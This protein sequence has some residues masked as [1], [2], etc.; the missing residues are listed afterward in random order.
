LHPF[1]VCCASLAQHFRQGSCFSI[2]CKGG[3]ACGLKACDKF[4][5]GFHSRTSG[6]GLSTP[7]TPR[8]TSQESERH[9]VGPDVDFE[10]SLSPPQPTTT[11]LSALRICSHL[12]A[13]A[14]LA[15]ISDCESLRGHRD[16]YAYAAQPFLPSTGRRLLPSQPA[17]G[18][19]S[20]VAKL[21]TFRFVNG[22][23]T[24]TKPYRRVAATTRAGSS[25]SECALTLPSTFICLRDSLGQATK[26]IAAAGFLDI[27]RLHDLIPIRRSLN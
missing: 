13:S 2:S 11:T 22:P 21:C 16:A 4:N 12:L 19:H 17:Q 18:G 20:Q 27:P 24:S 23:T 8:A 9:S 7:V 1:A 10:S 6:V 26:S 5:F 14:S 15:G 25:E 3:E